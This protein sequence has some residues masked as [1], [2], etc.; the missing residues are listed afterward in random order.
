MYKSL[1]QFV[2]KDLGAQQDVRQEYQQ[3]QTMHHRVRR[4]KIDAYEKLRRVKRDTSTTM[5]EEAKFPLFC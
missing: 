3:I 1:A 2:V 4:E 5:F